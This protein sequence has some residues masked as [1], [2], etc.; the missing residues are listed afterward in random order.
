M[1]DI[2]DNT[3]RSRLLLFLSFFFFMIRR[4]PRS[5]RTDT[6]F[7][8]TTLVRSHDAQHLSRGDKRRLELALCL[9]AKPRLLL[10][11]EPT[12]GMSRHDT[13]STID[14]IGRAHV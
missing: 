3:C 5:T 7:P 11:D 13:N 10:L 6:L 9:A 4:P 12:A 14:Q 2:T 8:Y 1:V